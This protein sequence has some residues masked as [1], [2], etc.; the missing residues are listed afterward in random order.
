[1]RAVNRW[2]STD[3]VRHRKAQRRKLHRRLAVLS[4]LGVALVALLTGTTEF[5]HAD[6][7]TVVTFSYTGASQQWTVP[8]G[9]TSIQVTAAGAQG[10]GTYGG[11]G[12]QAQA[13]LAVTPGQILN[14]YVGGQGSGRNGGFNGGGSLDSGSSG[15][16]G[17]GGGASDVRVGGTALANRVLVAGGGG[18]AGTGATSI[19][20][21]GGSG[22][23]TTGEVGGSGSG[24]FTGGGGGTQ[25]AGGASGGTLGIAGSLGQ[26]G[27]SFYQ[28]GCGGGGYYGGGGGASNSSGG[29]AGGGGG[30]SSYADPGATSVSY[31]PGTQTGNGRITITYP[32]SSGGGTASPGSATFS[33]TGS[34]Q[35]WT[36][37]TGVTS[38]SVQAYGAQGAGTYGGFGAMTNATIPV[39]PGE[40]LAITVGGQGS[41]TSGGFNGGGDS[42]ASG[43]SAGSGGGGATDVRAGGVGLGDRVVIAG[44]GGGG[45]DGPVFGMGGSAGQNG[46]AGGAGDNVFLG[47]GGGTQ[48]A[49]GASGGDLAGAGVLGHGANSLYI[50]GGGGG[51]YYGGGSGGS[52]ST[53]GSPA[54]GGGGSSFAEA[55]A[56]HVSF[57]TGARLGN[58]TVTI[59]WPP[60]A[61]PTLATGSGGVLEYSYTGGP[62]FWTVPAGITQ[63]QVSLTGG[64]GDPGTGTGGKGGAEEGLVPVTPGQV[65]SII[66]GGRG[67]AKTGGFN[68]GGGNNSRGVGA[69]GGGA[70]DIRVGG[71]TLADRILVAGGAGGGGDGGSTAHGGDGGG[72]SGAAGQT[73]SGSGTGG[74]GGTQ[75]AGGTG[76]GLVRETNGSL[77]AGGRDEFW[78]GD[79]GGG[80]YGGGTGATGGPFDTAGGGGGGSSFAAPS[81]QA[82]S[83]QSGVQAGDGTAVIDT[84]MPPL[85]QS[86]GVFGDSGTHAKSGTH[87]LADPVNT[88]T[89][90]FMSTATDLTLAAQG[91]SFAYTRT[92]TSSDTTVGRLGPG[93]TDNY[94]VSLAVQS[95]GDVVLHGD[96]GQL[97]SFIKQADGSFVG[98]AGTLSTLST[99]SGGY[100]LVRHDQVT[101]TFNSAGVLQSELDRNGQGL[102]FNYDGSGRLSTINDASSHT[103]TFGYSGSSTLVSS[104]TTPDNRVVGYGYTGGSLT[105]VTLPDPDGSGP[106]TSPVWN[107]TYNAAGQ[108]WQVIDPNSKTQSTTLYDANTGRVTQVSDANNK[109]THFDWNATTQTAT[110]TDADNHVWT[111]V[112]QN[113]VLVQEQDPA[114]DTTKYGHDFSIDTNAVTAP[115]GTNT[116]QMTYQNGNLMSATAPASLGSNVQKTF[117]YTAQN[118]PQDITDAKQKVTHY[119]YDAAGN[120]NAITLAGQAVFSANYNAQGQM[121]NSTDGNGQQTTYTYDGSG[122]V[123]SV[124]S[125][126]PDGV[127]PLAASQTTYTYDGMGNVVTMVDARG[128]CSGCTAANHTT[129]YTYDKDG[130]LLTETDP[131]GNCSGCNAAAHTTTYTYDAAGNQKTVQ[132]A[133]G[134]TTTYDYDNAN[135]LIKVTGADPDG[136][137]PLAAPVTTYTYD[138]AGNR[139]TMVD[140]R[141][142][143]SGCNAA[144]HTTTYTYNQNNQLASVTTPKGEKTTYFYD[145]NGNLSSVVDPRGNVTGANPNDYSTTYT[146]DAAGRLLTT[147]PPDPDGSGPLHAATA[148][149]HY[150]N[151]GNLD[152]SK[153]L[154]QHQTNYTYDAA[155]RVLTVQAPDGGM[156]TYTYDGDGSLQTRKDDNNHITTYAYDNAE[157]LTSITG[158]GTSPP[159]T[160]Y[161]YDSNGNVATLTDPNGNATPASGDGTTS[162]TYD[163]ANRLTD[164]TYS[165]SP[166]TPNVHFVLDGVGNRTSMTDGSGTVAYVYDNLNRLLSATRGTDAFSYA[167]DDAGNVTS[168]TYP[169]SSA[170]T[171]A[172]DE[173]N[174]LQTV[175]SGTAATNYTYWPNGELNQTTLPN[176]YVETRTYDNEARLT[177][178]KNAKSGT[179]LSEFASTLDDAGNP[180]QIVQTGASPATQTYGYDVNDRLTSVCFQASCPNSTD[181]KISWTY[182]KVGNRQTE[183]RQATGTS[184]TY[185]YNALDELTSAVKSVPGTNPYSTQVQTDGASAYW[186]LGETTGTTFASTV[187]SFTGTWTGSP[188][189]GA[190]GALTGDSNTAVTLNNTGQSTQSGSV[191]NATGLNKTN[192]FSLE[193]WIKRSSGRSGVLQ[194]VAGKPLSTTTHNENYAIWLTTANKPQ[195]EVGAG[196]SGN[197]SAVITSSVAISDTTNWYHVVGT[198]ASGVLKI[199]VNGALAGTNSAAGF[200]TVTTNTSTFDIGHSGTTNYL[201]GTL[202]EIAVY[203]TALTA[204]QV[205]DHYNKGTTTP[206]PVQTT[207]NYVYDNNG[208]ETSAG[209]ANLTYDLANRLK[210]YASGGTTTTYSY[211]GRGNRLQ[212]STGSLASQ[213]TNYLWDT[214]LGLPQVALERDGSNAVLR[215]YVYGARRISMT[216]GGGSYY[217]EYDPSGSVANLTSSSGATEWTYS[218]EPFGSANGPPTRNDPNA[219]VNLFEFDGEYADAIGQYNLRAREYDPTI[220][221]FVAT[222]PV[223]TGMGQLAASPY[224][225]A[226]NRPTV[227][228]DPSGRTFEP[229]N[230]GVAAATAPTSLTL[231]SSGQS[232]PL[233][234]LSFEGWPGTGTGVLGGRITLGT[235]LF[236]AG[237]AA[238]AQCVIEYGVNACL[239]HGGSGNEEKSKCDRAV[240]T[241]QIN[242]A[243]FGDA[244]DH[245]LRACGRVFCLTY[246]PAGTAMRRAANLKASGLPPRGDLDRDEE[247]PAAFAESVNASVEYTS[248]TANRSL[249]AYWG[250]R[251]QGLSPGSVVKFILSGSGGIPA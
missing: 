191:P 211:D 33:Y 129:T 186:R 85:A 194:A 241:I 13:T 56:T 100:K 74:G 20:G 62:R 105:S 111:D 131:L 158:P 107:Y 212:A 174:R 197:K 53:G 163:A 238:L 249:G 242:V 156:T 87:V 82:P 236:G 164:I 232:P 71:V 246:D 239:P 17:G 55:S 199:Y 202:D 60:N 94:A 5:A 80:Y 177:D 42:T 120:N 190:T 150:D 109:V 166:T 192:N 235:G 180:T 26:G 114:G 36:V 184:T 122:N 136:N 121:L 215:R 155:G 205:T 130:H 95:N 19:F 117:T 43:G 137:G 18:G 15:T 178:L 176:S 182:D 167:Y 245:M 116:T 37:P 132:D 21:T 76:S 65:V 124:T 61:D 29:S 228:A 7:P 102:A 40:T 68:G 145:A 229:S 233:T 234:L 2:S 50:G 106:L 30:G 223:A 243:D 78:G 173:D 185:N 207:T 64:A 162:Y 127:G 59:T 46:E 44:G 115:D 135:H 171:Y 101:Y 204:T 170:T 161:T 69:A 231:P 104:I 3:L 125:P 51:G 214:T 220:G 108:L 90:A 110:V 54:G 103:I 175:T 210:T 16:A 35:T 224:S 250:A 83:T 75:T 141:G 133:N 6:G 142:N 23:S 24:G 201:S 96:E 8:T 9:V 226:A 181:P 27:G 209:S 88:L 157:R 1:M 140:P 195:F 227:L 31:V 45:D 221:R 66:V 126:D 203:G 118:D 72:V 196:G 92:Y 113:N 52:N 217:Y 153:D 165:D 152:W 48:S 148:T 139:L 11:F 112:Y 144:Q 147:T 73:G 179:T 47:G 38:V 14:I 4:G 151:V 134:H 189:L 244:G 248:K 79:G 251:I 99:I 119:G 188:T 89:G 240:R 86:F 187:G 123:A 208:N 84:G 39:T 97:V 247:P 200:T 138:D 32:P 12:A 22:G 159:L 128:N 143:C 58:G 216:S 169:G 213:K 193:L 98:A 172:Y 28:G 77:G 149:N 168:R 225:F 63:V 146:Y 41:G 10:D 230:T 81:V 206:P 49:G 57:I 70:S 222:D 67:V 154:N 91:V 219:P 160:T 237:L 93:W 198:F 25:T 218:Y 183:T 34:L